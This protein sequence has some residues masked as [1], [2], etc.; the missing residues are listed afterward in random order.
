MLTF[1]ALRNL[2]YLQMLIFEVSRNSV[3]SQMLIFEVSRIPVYLQMLIF[4][5]S[6]NSVYYQMPFGVMK[7]WGL[8]ID[9][10]L[11]NQFRIPLQL[12]INNL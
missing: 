9:L 10:F 2:V 4:D 3:Y 11:N 1:G 5:V 7:T 6:R 12:L 8:R